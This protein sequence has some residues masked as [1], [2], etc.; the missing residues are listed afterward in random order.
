MVRWFLKRRRGTK[1]SVLSS[2]LTCASPI[3]DREDSRGGPAQP[4]RSWRPSTFPNHLGYEA[5][6]CLSE[7]PS[8]G[9][10]PS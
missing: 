1:W 6:G 10:S 3:L 4:R 9:E 5:T 7:S 2:F 8:K